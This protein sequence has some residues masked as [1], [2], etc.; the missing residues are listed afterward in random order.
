MKID[1][2]TIN[3]TSQHASLRQV[4]VEES[5]RAWVGQQRPNFE[6]NRTADP[7]PSI[8]PIMVSIS[9]AG[10]Q[11]AVNNQTAEILDAANPT[12]NDPKML[13]LIS[14]IESLTGQKVKVFNPNDLNLSDAQVQAQQ[15]AQQAAS[16]SSQA[17][18][19]SQSAQP[20][21]NQ[22]QGWGIEYD[23]HETVHESEQTSF[24]AQGVIK[25]SDG[26]EIQFNLS[27][28]MK[29]EFTQQ[30]DVSIRKGDAVKK[31]PMVINFDGTAAQLTDTKFSFDLNAD[32]KAEKISFVGAGSGF[33][34]L[35]KNG[36]G[37]IDN[38]SELFGT[39]SGNSF[40]DLK[41]YDSNGNNWIDQNDAIY[42]RLRVWSKNAAGKDTLS[43]LAQH[44]VGALYLGNIA[45]P[46]DL[47][48]AA[49][50]L[51]GQVRSS[52]VYVKEDGSTGTLQQVDLVV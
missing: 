14:L 47:N 7:A 50:E 10:Q 34:A 46:F 38:G 19:A 16:Q 24:S 13:L 3:L 26:K 52:G 45:T 29:R 49:H 51:Q 15:A 23:K 5:L 25:T 11:A 36:N 48:N 35:D 32:G 37:V 43:T 2:S 9:V 12:S 6:G 44:N 1:S 4:T 42:S 27:V 21:Q 39:Q 8:Q 17:T 20:V 41:A 28:D 40:A 33:L 18:Q 22:R 30:T 31:D